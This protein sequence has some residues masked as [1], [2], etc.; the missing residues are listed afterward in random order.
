MGP[1]FNQP[2]PEFLAEL[3]CLRQARSIARTP[4]QLDVLVNCIHRTCRITE[5]TLTPE[6]IAFWRDEL[7]KREPTYVQKALHEVCCE[8]RGRVY[9]ADVLTRVEKYVQRNSAVL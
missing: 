8:V 7:A 2:S 6:Q 1:D 5:T 9:L 3:Q 4:E